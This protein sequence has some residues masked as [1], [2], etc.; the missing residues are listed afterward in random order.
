MFSCE[1]CEI[2]KNSFFQKE[3]SLRR[4]MLFILLE[5]SIT[6]QNFSG[7]KVILFRSSH[8]EMFIRKGVIKIYSKFT[9]EH[10]CR[11]VISQLYWNHTSVWVFSCKFAAYF[12]NTFTKNTSEWLLLSFVSKCLKEIYIIIIWTL[13]FWSSQSQNVLNLLLLFYYSQPPC[14]YEVFYMKV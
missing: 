1:F 4:I 5:H 8:P 14:S 10:S 9:G 11:S 7:V 13:C 3:S 2:L 6:S 12:Q